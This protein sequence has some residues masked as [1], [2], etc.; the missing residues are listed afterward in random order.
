MI[1][2]IIAAV[3]TAGLGIVLGFTVHRKINGNEV[4]QLREMHKELRKA[5]QSL[6]VEFA[7]KEKE[8]Q[9]W[10]ER[11]SDLLN[12]RTEIKNVLAGRDKL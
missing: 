10:R 2:E 4:K 9:L 11:Y 12:V 1:L 5:H 3:M 6:S 8:S 7:N